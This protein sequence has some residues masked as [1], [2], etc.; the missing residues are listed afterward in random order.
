MPHPPLG[1]KAA[2]LLPGLIAHPRLPHSRTDRPPAPPPKA[3]MA[4]AITS[5]KHAF[6]SYQITHNHPDPRSGSQI[7]R[8][9]CA[10]TS[11]MPGNFKYHPVAKFRII[12]HRARIFQAP[13]QMIV[14][15]VV[16][17][18]MKGECHHQLL[19]NLRNLWWYLRGPDSEN[20]D[21]SRSREEEL[22]WMCELCLAG[23]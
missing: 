8:L 12:S 20:D 7:P 3:A 22:D 13:P 2:N 14:A 5:P 11:R 1:P 6:S 4:G 15:V 10:R 19:S 18:L 23:G 21:V 9:M 16:A 17:C